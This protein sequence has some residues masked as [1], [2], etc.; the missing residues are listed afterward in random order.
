MGRRG[1]VGWLASHEL[2]TARPATSKH[3][4][5]SPAPHGQLIVDSSHAK[6]GLVRPNLE[7]LFL[8]AW[9]K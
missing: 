7:I 3:G 1:G 5:T 9:Q 2:P 8:P 4:D 6:Y